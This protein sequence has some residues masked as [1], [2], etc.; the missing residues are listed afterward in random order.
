MA[1]SSHAASLRQDRDVP[2][3]TVAEQF[4]DTRQQHAAATLGMWVFLA[5]E[6]L[7]FGVVFFGYALLRAHFP[8][9]FAQA[10]RHTKIVLGT[11]NTAI[12]LTSSL[13]MVLAVRASVLRLPRPTALLLAVTAGLGVIFAALKITEYLLDWHDH[14]IPVLDF[15]FDARYATGALVFFWFYFTT[16]LLHLVHL[17]IGVGLVSSFALRIWITGD[18]LG[19]KVEVTGLYWHFVDIVWIFLYPLLYLVSRS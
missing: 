13:T 12:L 1:M 4:D 7:F 18:P 10:S 11:A 14:L 3:E 2:A 15:Q 17:S 6:I 8:E 19:D 5:T 16:T 9:A